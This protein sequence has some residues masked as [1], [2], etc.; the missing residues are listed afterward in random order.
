MKMII[1]ITIILANLSFAQSSYKSYP[2]EEAFD[3]KKI[4]AHDLE[5]FICSTM[6][7]D[8]PNYYHL[9]F[10][11]S[12]RKAQLFLLTSEGP[13]DGYI[14]ELEAGIGGLFLDGII[15]KD[16]TSFDHIFWFSRLI[17]APLIRVGHFY[18]FDYP[19]EELICEEM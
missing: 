5:T 14:T 16:R 15:K 6:E 3:Y 18:G 8:D 4:D 12:E 1:S 11:K 2:K 19:R 17:E 13:K 10:S 7:S 9:E